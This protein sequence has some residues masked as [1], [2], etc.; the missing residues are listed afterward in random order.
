MLVGV[1]GTDS[2]IIAC[3]YG[4]APEGSDRLIFGYEALVRITDAHGNDASAP[5]DLVARIV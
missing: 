3:H 1:C 5:G 2:E 4:K